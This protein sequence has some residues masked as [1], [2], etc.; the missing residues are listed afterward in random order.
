MRSMLREWRSH[1]MCSNHKKFSP[2][3]I[4][5]RFLDGWQARNSLPSTHVAPSPVS[6]DRTKRHNSKSVWYAKNG[7]RWHCRICRA[8]LCRKLNTISH[9]PLAVNGR[10]NCSNHVIFTYDNPLIRRYSH[11]GYIQENFAITPKMSTYLVAFMVSDLVNTNAS[12]GVSL[13]EDMPEINIWTRKDVA[14]MTRCAAWIRLCER[15][16]ILFLNDFIACY[17]PTHRY[18]YTLS[19][20]LLPFYERY[21]GISFKLPKIDMVAVPDFGFS[22]IFAFCTLFVTFSDIFSFHFLHAN[23]DPLNS[24]G[25]QWTDHVPVTI[26]MTFTLP[27]SCDGDK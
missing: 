15:W 8:R 16:K 14:D 10:A 6:I 23:P 2:L 27:T 18:A 1:K 24:H 11:P 17:F 20:K 13:P 26:Y 3:L 7:N 12:R 21:F 22:G 19:T 4:L 25:E 9:F 5:T